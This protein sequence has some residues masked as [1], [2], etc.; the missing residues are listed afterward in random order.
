MTPL[1]L[2]LSI[3]LAADSVE[4]SIERWREL[5]P[6][7]STSP[8]AARGEPWAATR[9][10]YL[11]A[12]QAEV[13]V[14]W[15]VVVP[16]SGWTR[17]QLSGPG[18]VPRR[19]TMNGREVGVTTTPLGVELAWD[20]AGTYELELHGSLAE[21][22][23][24]DED[25]SLLPAGVGRVHLD[26][27]YEV[28]TGGRRVPRLE[29]H[30]TGAQHLTLQPAAPPPAA[31]TLVVASVA[32]GLTVA[33]SEVR[34]HARLRWQV[35]RGELTRV[36]LRT[37]G[38]PSDATLE[39][40]GARARRSGDSWEV[41][42]AEP[43][44]GSLALDLTWS[45]PLLAADSQ[46]VD[47]QE[48]LLDDVVRTEELLAIARDSELDVL[49]ELTGGT[50]RSVRSLPSWADGV[51]EGE[52]TVLR[53]GRSR[54]HLQV[55]RYVPVEQPALL[56]DVADWDLTVTEEGRLLGA[57]TLT[58]RNSH[59]SH[60]L[61]QLPD[62]LRPVSVIVDGQPVR[63]APTE[64]GWRI[65]LPRSVNTLEGLLSFP[66]EIGMLGTVSA[67]W[68]G[69]HVS[70]LPMP[71]VG[72]PVAVR[73]TT[74]HLPRGWTSVGREGR[75]GL[76][77]AFS[78]GE[79]LA[80]GFGEQSELATT[81]SVY[82]QALDAWLSNDFG[83]AQA[84]LDHLEAQG[85]GNENTRRLQSN[86]D[87]V[88]DDDKDG[89]EAMGRRLMEEARARA[90]DDER[91]QADAL[92]LAKEA[93]RSGAYDVAEAQYEVALKLSDRLEAVEN[94]E[95]VEQ[96]TV[97]VMARRSLA[98]VRASKA[99]RAPVEEVAEAAPE[100]EP[101]IPEPADQAGLS[102]NISWSIASST[103]GDEVGGIA[104]GETSSRPGES[105]P[106]ASFTPD[107]GDQLQLTA[108]SAAMLLPVPGETLHYQHL[109]L[110]QGDHTPIALSVKPT[111]SSR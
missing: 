57:G 58:L 49:P 98:K 18:I 91:R 83:T 3:A 75:A 108:T 46:N 40:A 42:L 106:V 39:G 1:Y 103:E 50:A 63:I 90:S 66:V 13:F 19:V 12:S 48:I 17:L 25:L 32:S 89:D 87:Y 59:A 111:H 22:L 31:G 73:R 78:E 29:V 53:T 86:L 71:T 36:T 72:A 54:G 52:L 76:V 67:G 93:E 10:V 5:L 82:R 74:V 101:I 96:S 6:P 20:R 23:R 80:Y 30:H 33:D 7:D 11:Q 100:P 14:R 16:S 21:P 69:R 81:T 85:L 41:V 61:V 27:P 107:T 8:E 47:I 88:A 94:E 26:G 28:V 37:P 110:A 95:A 77:P 43:V 35:R 44:S 109:L 45:L 56:V 62:G 99:E 55:M 102:P 24:G 65:P 51:V 92:K 104:E 15:Q 9:D 68:L 4:L 70:P 34:G 97:T 60:L 105:R 79:G 64:H 2:L 84:Q 38:L